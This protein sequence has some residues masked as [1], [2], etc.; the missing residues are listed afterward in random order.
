MVENNT[1]S[2]EGLYWLKIV[3]GL[4]FMFGFGFLPATSTLTTAGMQVLGIF[5]RL[6][7]DG[8]GIGLIIW[9]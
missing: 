7:Y 6:W 9:Q 4:A 2:R 8:Q 3:I 1:Q 5:I